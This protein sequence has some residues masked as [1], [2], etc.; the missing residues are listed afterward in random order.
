MR[1]LPHNT[2]FN[3]QQDDSLT[4]KYL[5]IEPT[6]VCN[7]DCMFCSRK[8]KRRPLKHMTLKE[9]EKIIQHFD[10]VE[11]IKL[12]GLGECFMTPNLAELL[13]FLKNKYPG[14]I[15]VCATNLN[16]KKTNQEL[17]SILK[18]LDILYLSLDGAT[19]RTYE[20]IRRGGKFNM[21]MRSLEQICALGYK[22]TIYSCNY[23]VSDKN[24]HEIGRIIQL[25]KQF[26]LNEVRLNLVQ[27][28]TTDNRL[29][30]KE[31]YSQEACIEE[32]HKWNLQSKHITK[33]IIT[34]VGDPFFEF[35]K[36]IWPFERMYIGVEGNIFVCCLNLDDQW[37]MG[38][39]F[40]QDLKK[41]FRQKR[42]EEIRE[43]LR[44]N[45]PTK[46]CQTCSYMIHREAL[47]KIKED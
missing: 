31:N 47:Q 7:L 14:V 44:H 41:V 30:T 39:I 3:Y 45:K 40:Q 17:L 8:F 2:M 4:I 11:F 1:T 12:Q 20:E 25:A 29:T 27:D 10:S 38:N 28:W 22:K 9:L 18:N 35:T 37:C 24:Y 42:M 21:A 34:I 43:G 32:L 33:P 46:H 19:Q 23:I 5:Q 16:W 26:G 15:T 36:C 6:S 13:D